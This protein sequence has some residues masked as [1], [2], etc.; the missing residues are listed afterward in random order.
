MVDLISM[1]KVRMRAVDWAALALL[2]FEAPSL[3][4]SQDR[5]NSV[6]ASEV[7]A[8]AVLAYFGLR[9]LARAPLRAAW[10]AALAGL[11]GAWLSLSGIVEFKA[12]TER[13]AAV[14]LTNFVAFRSSLIYPVRG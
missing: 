14:G 1:A 4:Y 8:L 13:L 2:A 7:L 11:G 3:L 10:L 12:G 6:R 9:L 5:A